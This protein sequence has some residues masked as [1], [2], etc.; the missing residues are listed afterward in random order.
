VALLCFLSTHN[1]RANT[2]GMTSM[3]GIASCGLSRYNVPPPTQTRT[4]TRRSDAAAK[5]RKQ[6][7]RNKKSIQ[8]SKS[9]RSRVPARAELLQKELTEVVRHRAAFSEVLRVIASSPDDLQPIFDIIIQSA[10]RLCRAT[11]GNLR[12]AEAEGSKDC[13]VSSVSSACRSRQHAKDEF[14]CEHQST[15]KSR[16]SAPKRSY[17]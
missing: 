14:N 12:L 5:T 10:T 13:T 9:H 7:R 3:G 17:A 8:G 1:T 11:Y 15:V 6:L 2:T 16:V 4:R